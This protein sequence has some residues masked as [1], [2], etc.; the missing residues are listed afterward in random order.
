MPNFHRFTI[1]AQEALQSAQELVARENHG[2]LKALHLLAALL[3]DDQTLIRPMLVRSH[4]NLAA[5]ERELEGEL[6]QFPKSFAASGAVNQLYL[7]QELMKIL[8]RAAEIALKHK[9]EF[10]SCEHLLLAL[11]DIPSPAQGFLERFGVRKDMLVRVLGQLRGSTR[12]TDETPES[13][14]Q[15]LDKYAVNVTDKASECER[16]YF[17]WKIRCVEFFCACPVPTQSFWKNFLK[18]KRQKSP[19]AQSK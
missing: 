1:K 17:Q 9:D 6:G 5:L 8:D 2:E 19:V 16:F 14:F 10:I 11:A 7:S 4:V 15:V 3:A 18:R 13:K 12:V